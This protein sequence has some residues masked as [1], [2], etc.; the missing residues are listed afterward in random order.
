M[1]DKQRFGLSDR[2]ESEIYVSR[3]DPAPP[4]RFIE[5]EVVLMNDD[6]HCRQA[7]RQK[8]SLVE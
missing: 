2:G 6:Q 5:V 3:N 7:G 4:R 8:E 1:S